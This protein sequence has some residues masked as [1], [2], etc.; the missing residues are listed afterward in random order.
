M[1]SIIIPNYN[2]ENLIG[3]TLK[4]I[5]NQTYTNWEC[6]IVDDGSTDDSLNVIQSFA[7]NDSRIKLF[8]R[9]K[10]LPKGANT[11]RNYGFE[12][13]KGKFINWFDSDDIMLPDFLMEHKKNFENKINLVISAGYQTDET[14]TERKL[15]NV[16]KNDYLFKDYFTGKIKAV[17]GAVV[18]RKSFLLNK[19]LFNEKLTRSQ[20]T[21]FFSRIFFK[22]NGDSYKLINKP[23]YLYRYHS[24]SKTAKNKNYVKSFNKSH[25]MVTIENYK[26]SLLLKDYDLIYSFSISLVILFYK[27]IVN[28][29]F[30]NSL[31]ILKNVLLLTLKSK[32]IF[33]ITF[34]FIYLPKKIINK[35]KK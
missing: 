24:Q 12:L 21:D 5:I 26:K 17:T 30:S 33:L 3:E 10:N 23:L 1:I 34:I 19:R 18:F 13:S 20:E 27:G 6:I 15:M 4:S 35:F 7:N 32:N 25:A 14:L 28:K 11:C 16:E 31:Y 2:R 22:L 29:H 8:K 9:P